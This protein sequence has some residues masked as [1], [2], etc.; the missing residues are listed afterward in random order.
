VSTRLRSRVI[1]LI[2]RGSRLPVVTAERTPKERHNATVYCRSRMPARAVHPAV[3]AD[4]MT[5]DGDVTE[6]TTKAQ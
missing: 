1:R 3:P 4:L 6:S 5:L 2:E